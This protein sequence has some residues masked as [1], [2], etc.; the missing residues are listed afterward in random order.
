M[1]TK[2]PNELTALEALQ[3]IEAG[4]LTSETLMEACLQR[5]AE[6]ESVVGAWEYLAS[7]G[8]EIGAARRP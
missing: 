1:A 8:D 4:T 2:A 6:R 7:R 3:S 5:I